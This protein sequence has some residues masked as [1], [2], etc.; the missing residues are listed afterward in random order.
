MEVN[1]VERGIVIDHIHPGYGLKVLEYLNIDLMEN[2]IALIINASSEKH[3]RKDIIKIEGVTD[4]DLTALGLVDHKATVNIIENGVITNKINLSLP[5]KVTNVIK[6]KNPR[7]VTS[8]EQSIPHIFHLVNE[9]NEEYSCEYC[10]E[11]I[12]VAT[13]KD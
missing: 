10:D 2:M 4:I 8:V 3:G 7:C 1:S 9:E 11:I 5:D 6:C 13:L 12:E